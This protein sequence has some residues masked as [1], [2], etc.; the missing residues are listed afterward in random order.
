MNWIEWIGVV[1]GIAAVYL[2]YLNNIWTW[3]IGFIN[4]GCFMILFWHQKLYGDFVVQIIFLVTG[5][6]GWYNWGNQITN[7][8]QKLLLKTLIFWILATILFIPVATYYLKNFTDCIYPIAEA[9]ILIISIIGQFLTSMRKIENWYWWIVADLLMLIV[10]LMKGLYPTAAYSLIIL[11]IG[12][13][14]LLKWRKLTII[15]K[16]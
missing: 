2:L 5:I 13:L 15:A 7:N 6:F 14:G 8:P 16:F 1:S 10:Y 4:I 3:P 9:T 12:I 11:I